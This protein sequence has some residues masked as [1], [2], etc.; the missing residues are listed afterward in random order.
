MLCVPQILRSIGETGSQF[1][2][3]VVKGDFSF[4]RIHGH[5]EGSIARAFRFSKCGGFIIAIDGIFFHSP[6]A[7]VGSQKAQRIMDSMRSFSCFS[8]CPF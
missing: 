8:F 4:I 5:Q 1:V 3:N 2:K 7:G 6:T